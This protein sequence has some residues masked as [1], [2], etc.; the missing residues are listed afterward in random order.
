MAKNQ[1]DITLALAAICQA[2]NLVT[3]LAEQ[4]QCD[5]Q[6][7]LTLLNSVF[8]IDAPSTLAIYGGHESNLRLGLQ[9][10]LTIFNRTPNRQQHSD[11]VALTRYALSLMVL[12]RK[13]AKSPTLLAQL[14]DRLQQ[15]NRQRQHFEIDSSTI[16]S[17]LAAVYVDIISPLG[18]KIQ[19][20][21]KPPYLQ[22][23][24]IQD[25][26]RALLFA[27]IRAAVLW[28]QIGGSRLHLLFSR[29]QL[30][31]QAELILQHC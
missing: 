3:Q 2:A 30:C 10:F 17:A 16:F 26:I 13:L 12:E 6:S 21:G 1:H 8:Q 31:Q 4:G 14:T 28:Q 11:P 15:V 24:L 19:I 22:N 23:N 7:Q 29:R 20:T 9:T 27:G 25:K 5:Y 18:A